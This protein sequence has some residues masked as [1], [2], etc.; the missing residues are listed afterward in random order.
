MPLQRLI[1]AACILLLTSCAVGRIESFPSPA[2]DP[3]ARL[4]V[5]RNRN[6]IGGCCTVKLSLDG[7][8]IA[9]LG[10]GEY[11][12]IP[13]T[14]GNHGVSAHNANL[15]LNY[16]RGRDY[17]LLVTVL[18]GGGG[19]ELEQIADTTARRLMSGYRALRQ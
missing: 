12:T 9:R 3:S 15:S 16:Q 2:P 19:F 8:L 18:P 7:V 4:T 11:L 1:A 17:F 10:N 14:P 6:A 5:L 13:V